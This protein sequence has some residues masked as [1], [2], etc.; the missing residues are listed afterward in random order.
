MKTSLTW[1]AGTGGDRRALHPCVRSMIACRK[2]PRYKLA[3]C[4][5]KPMYDSGST[6]CCRVRL[7]SVELSHPAGAATNCSPNLIQ[8]YPE[9]RSDAEDSF[10]EE[11]LFSIVVRI[12]VPKAAA[13]EKQTAGS[14]VSQQ[15]RGCHFAVDLPSPR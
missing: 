3:T 9:S 10:A 2:K 6:S 1:H 14:Y 15:A 12:R 8:I 11:G 13:Q 7:L 4:H 5:L